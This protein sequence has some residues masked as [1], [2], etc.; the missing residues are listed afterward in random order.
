MSS[1]THYFSIADVGWIDFQTEYFSFATSGLPAD[2]HYT[3][4]FNNSSSFVNLHLSKNINTLGEK[5]RIYLVLVDKQ[6]AEKLYPLLF[7]SLLDQF[8]KPVSV[9]RFHKRALFIPNAKLEGSQFQSLIEQKLTDQFQDNIKF[10]RNRKRLKITGAIGGRIESVFSAGDTLETMIQASKVF[11]AHR[12][13]NLEAGVIISN[14]QALFVVKINDQF[15]EFNINADLSS[16]LEKE[17]GK[18]F[19]SA[20]KSYIKRSI[21]HLRSAKQSEDVAPF[22][23]PLVFKPSGI[24]T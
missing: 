20:L 23:K 7:R 22:S 11:R 3:I 1:A 21:V 10:K 24:S 12:I 5:P 8:L 16:W 6:Y 2:I 9:K 17:L 15:F 4:A 13:K 19:M 14:E 18:K